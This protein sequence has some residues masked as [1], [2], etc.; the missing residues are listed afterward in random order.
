MNKKAIELFLAE[1]K[2]TRTVKAIE[3]LLSGD[4]GVTIAKAL[5]ISKQ[6]VY[7]IRDKYIKV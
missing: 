4:G 5:G 3:L 2:N 1:H 7:K 6:A